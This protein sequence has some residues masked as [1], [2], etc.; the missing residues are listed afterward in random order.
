MPAA[1][2]VLIAGCGDVGMRLAALLQAQGQRVLCL[3]RNVAALAP[4]LPGFAADLADAASL[5]A[6]PRGIRRVV[7][8]PAPLARE[9]VAYRTVYLAG[10]A[11]L[12]DALDAL[13]ARALQRCVLV[14]SSAVYGEH[15]GAWVDEGTPPAPLG[16][17]GAILLAAEALLLAR[18]GKSRG[19]VLRLAGLYGPGRTRLLDNLRN[20]TARAPRDPPFYANRIHVDDAAA[21]LAHLLALPDPASVYLGV[22]DTPLPLHELYAALARQLRAPAPGIG[23]PVPDIGNKRLRNARLRASGWVPRWP[24]TRAGYAALRVDL[25]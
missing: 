3:R 23:P 22:D 11:N 21:A 16:F 10:L 15:A 12:L 25:A 1:A 19:V 18:L 5:R 4:G 2:P 7:F 24:D 14:T 6:L 13:D 20:G 17:N 9:A 8:L